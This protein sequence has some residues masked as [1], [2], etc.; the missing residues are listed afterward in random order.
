MNATT[1]A[2]R[3]GTVGVGTPRKRNPLGGY[4]SPIWL[5]EGMATDA[6]EATG[7]AFCAALAIG[8]LDLIGEVVK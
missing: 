8:L 1:P 7:P 2:E 3:A 6:L 5:A 4:F